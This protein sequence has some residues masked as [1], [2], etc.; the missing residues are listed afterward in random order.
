MANL[1]A[2]MLD[3]VVAV[4]DKK[5]YVA[6]G[7]TPVDDA[8][9]QVFVYDINADYWSWLPPPGHYYG[10]PHI[11]GGRL[12]IIGGR[13]SYTNI[14]TNKV[15]TFDETSQTWTSYYPNLL[16]VRDRPGVASHLDHV[17]VAG[18]LD[19]SLVVQDDIEI[20][21]WKENSCW[22]KI[23][24][25]LPVPMSIFAPIVVDDYLFIGDCTA[26]SFRRARLIYKIPVIKIIGSVK[27]QPSVEPIPLQSSILSV[28]PWVI[29]TGATHWSTA[30]VPSSSPLVVVGGSEYSGRTTTSDIMMYDDSS[31]SW[32]NIGSLS[33]PRASVAIAALND[34]AIIVIGGYTNGGDIA[35][36][37]S[38]SLTTVEVGQFTNQ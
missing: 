35:L 1:P 20:L 10:I 23:S 14:V 8:F 26:S 18:G 29:V 9:D 19:N 33:F 12:A 30:L 5:I 32:K 6:G 28:E 7:H 11:I 22:K 38:S 25:T 4:L 27:S 17:I 34:N 16:S 36:A 3:A 24:I 31:K 2:P 15:S 13:P 37:T 21:N